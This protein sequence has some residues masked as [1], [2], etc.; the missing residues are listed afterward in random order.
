MQALSVLRY[1]YRVYP[2]AIQERALAK[3]FGCVRTVWNDAVALARDARASG[4]KHA[5]YVELT[6]LL[7][8]EAK[9]TK[10]R[11]WLSSVSVVPLQQ[12]LR[13][14]DKARKQAFRSIK[15]ERKRVN[16]PRFKSKR[17]RQSAGFTKSGF[18]LRKSRK[19][20]LAKIGELK[21]RW[22]RKLP[23]DPSSVIITKDCDGRYHVSFVVEVKPKPLPKTATTVGVDL[24][25][26]DFAALSDGT[27]IRNPRHYR[28]AEKKLG[29]LQRSLSRKQKGS[30]R[31]KRARL[32]VARQH[33]KVANQRKDFLHKLSTRIA[34]ENQT[35]S[36]EDLN[37]QGMGR[38]MLS[39]SVMHAGWAM[40]RRML[41]YKA[42]AFGRRLCIV[43]RFFPS[44]KMCSSCGRIRKK[45]PLGMSV[46]TCDGCGVLHDRD[47]NAAKNIDAAGQAESKNGRGETVR[48]KTKSSRAVLMKRQPIE[49]EIRHADT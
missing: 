9:R 46:W 39:K 30:N 20:Y 13:F 24:G 49:C 43:D 48:P 27:K 31:R 28:R 26:T 10:E 33:S 25:L 11:A 34:R 15:G 45:M 21:V 22:S 1:T 17:S 36:L 12:T 37:V 29:H 6:K 14:Y 40:F 5:G 3:L 44:S 35:V 8:T 42:T 47:I 2:T 4:R 38:S 41:E 18:R 32:K 7:I 23:S 16:F 19:L